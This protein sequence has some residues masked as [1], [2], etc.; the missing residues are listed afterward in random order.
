MPLFRPTLP[1]NVLLSLKDLFRFHLIP[2]LSLALCGPFLEH[3]PSLM[4]RLRRG[5]TSPLRTQTSWG[6]HRF[7]RSSG[8]RGGHVANILTRQVGQIKAEV[9]AHLLTIRLSRR[10]RLCNRKFSNSGQ[11]NKRRQSRRCFLNG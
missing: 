4:A 7:Q 5:T 2:G 3:G 8:T 9:Y 10:Y 6:Y 1:S 11:R